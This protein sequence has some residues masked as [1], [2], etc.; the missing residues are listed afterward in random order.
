MTTE[1]L[2][3]RVRS[4][5]DKLDRG[6]L[7]RM[8]SYWEEEVEDDGYL[9]FRGLVGHFDRDD[10]ELKGVVVRLLDNNEAFEQAD[11]EDND[12]FF[13]KEFLASIVRLQKSEFWIEL[14]RMDLEHAEAKMARLLGA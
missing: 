5:L 9:A 14:V 13:E 2:R 12:A 8:V 11:E 1:Q 10:E 7:L 6:M 3:S 4:E